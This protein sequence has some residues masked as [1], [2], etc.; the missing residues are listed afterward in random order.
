MNE[1]VTMSDTELKNAVDAVKERELALKTDA[2]RKFVVSKMRG[3]IMYLENLGYKSDADGNA[4]AELWANS[5]SEEFAILGYDGMKKAVM[6]WAEHDDSEYRFFPKIPW[7]KDACSKVGG[8]PRA[9]MGRRIQAEQE[10]KIQEDHEREMAEFKAKHPDLWER[11][12]TLAKSVM[13]LGDIRKDD[14][15]ILG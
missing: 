6:Y 10:R 14:S 4:L 9:E 7:I 1:L 3:L 5:L 8:D 2:G 12:E 15:D 13:S 11:A